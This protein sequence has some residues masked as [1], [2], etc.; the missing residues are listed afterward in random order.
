[1]NTEN[2]QN[3]NPLSRYFRKPAIY[4]TLP[5]GGMFMSAESIKFDNEDAKEL[6][7]YPMTARDEM[8]FNTPDALLSGQSTVDVIQSCVPGIKNC[9]ELSS[10]D[11]DTV[12]I[13]IR[14]AS[15]GENMSVS[16]PVPNTKESVDVQVD[17]R[18]SLERI[19]NIKFNAHL[20]IDNNLSVQVKPNN[21]RQ[22][23][24]L[25]LKAF[26]EQR[27]VQQIAK[28][29]DMDPKE[30][31][32]RYN[33]V[34]R[35][36]TNL[37]LS[38]MI[39]SIASFTLDTETIVDRSQINEFVNNMDT[40]MATKIK[41]HIESQSKIGKMKPIEIAGTADQIKEGAPEK[42]EQPVA[43]DNSNFFASKS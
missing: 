3:T 42:W 38:N 23:T 15:Y 25:Q 5:S 33:S 37:T 31:D 1:M 10:I 26:E 35:N 22:L 29:D 4:I 6:A 41:K 28:A 14:I 17:L 9:W 43:L 13:A 36:M 24:N 2:T 27:L 21:Y 7:V 30:R 34:F 18:Q 32:E 16:S 39:D 12:I 8:T 19:D 11:L 40:G 20:Q